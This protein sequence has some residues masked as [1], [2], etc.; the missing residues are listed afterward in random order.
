MVESMRNVVKTAKFDK[1]NAKT[2]FDL[3]RN[4]FIFVQ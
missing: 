3:V 1:E 2:A 4:V